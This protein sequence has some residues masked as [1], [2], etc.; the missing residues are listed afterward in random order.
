MAALSNYEDG[1]ATG[2][3]LVEFREQARRPEVIL[4][5]IQSSLACLAQADVDNDGDL[6]LFVGGRC[7]PGRFPER[8]S[9]ICY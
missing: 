2:M 7:I 9:P 6:D 3:S 5:N 1:M 4:S 8:R